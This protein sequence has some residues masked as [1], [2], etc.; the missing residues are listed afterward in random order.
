MHSPGQLTR[1]SHN[2]RKVFELRPKDSVVVENDMKTLEIR[3]EGPLSGVYLFYELSTLQ[4][5]IKETYQ[6]GWVPFFTSLC[7]VVGGVVT[8]MSMV[9]QIIFR[10]FR[11]CGSLET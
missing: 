5:T 10:S 4:V 9:D 3:D 1:K 11:K 8:I 6:K 2:G 7:A